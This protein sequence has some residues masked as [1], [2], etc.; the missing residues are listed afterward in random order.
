[1]NIKLSASKQESG[2]EGAWLQ[3]GKNNIH[4]HT[5][6]GTQETDGKPGIVIGYD[7]NNCADDKA[8]RLAL[9]LTDGSAILQVVDPY[10]KK[11]TQTEL[12][13]Q[14][15]FDEFKKFLEKLATYA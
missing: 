6:T 1:M 9:S 13:P 14:I 5:A 2:I 3:Q 12:S 10:S 8:S 7:V 4:V 11:A 15:V